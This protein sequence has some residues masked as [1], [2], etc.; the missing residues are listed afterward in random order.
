M[1]DQ[2]KAEAL[3]TDANA[4]KAAIELGENIRAK[5]R[6]ITLDALHR[7]K[8]DAQETRRV[9][10]SVMQ[11]A[12]L[13]VSKAGDRTAQALGEALAGMDEALA[14]S[15]EAYKLAVEEAAGRLHDFSKHDLEKAFN[16]LRTLESMLLD[17]LKEV[18]DQ[19]AGEAR[20]I[21]Q[22]LAQHTKVNATSAGAT[23]TAAIASL[24]KRLGRTLREV[25]AAGSDVA[26]S[27][28]SKLADAAA[29]ILAGLAD[30]LHDQAK[31][32]REK[33]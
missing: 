31:N 3:S 19:S 23:A 8:L 25:A 33:K 21:F 24:E 12:S 5:V 10:S 28:T 9:L 18:A 27:T 30:A 1:I 7:G 15:A 6:K 2:G 13:G 32:L 20:D 14:K 29:G 17:T 4:V 26:L 11:G 16:N 22:T